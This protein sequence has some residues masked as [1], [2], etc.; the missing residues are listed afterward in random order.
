MKASP[1]MLAFL[2]VASASTWA[3]PAATCDEATLL[4]W[5]KKTVEVM[6]DEATLNTVMP[7]ECWPENRPRAA[8]PPAPESKAAP[9]RPDRVTRFKSFNG[10]LR[11]LPSPK[12]ES[13]SRT[14]PINYPQGE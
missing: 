7:V 2:T 4:A 13:S 8:L 14:T 6:D 11:T 10:G 12:A 1:L 3:A 5:Y 9:V